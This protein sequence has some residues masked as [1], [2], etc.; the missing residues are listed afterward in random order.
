MVE[1]NK[2]KLSFTNLNNNN[3]NNNNNNFQNVLNDAFNYQTI[4]K[5]PERI[6]KLKPYIN[7][8][9]W[10]GIDF[11]E[12]PKEWIKFEK[13]NKAIALDLLHV[14]HIAKTINVLYRSKYNNKRKKK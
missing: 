3:N 10:E 8:Y 1:S 5:I 7:K 12:K 13:N 6:S 14:K 9:N 11:P 2:M 4:E